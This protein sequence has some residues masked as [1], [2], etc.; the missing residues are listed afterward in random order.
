MCTPYKITM[1]H[2]WL[3][4]PAPVYHSTKQHFA[5]TV[6]SAPVSRA[7]R[8]PKRGISEPCHVWGDPRLRLLPLLLVITTPSWVR[9]CIAH[10][11]PELPLSLTSRILVPGSFVMGTSL[12]TQVVHIATRC[13][14]VQRALQGCKPNKPQQYLP[15]AFQTPKCTLY[16]HSCAR[17]L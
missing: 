16:C 8:C 17:K 1:K 3:L 11:V 5:L 12:L 14:V 13:D 2:I 9:P 15:P 10:L 4:T 6:A 7:P